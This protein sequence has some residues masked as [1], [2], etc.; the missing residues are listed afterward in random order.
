MS[1]TAIHIPE[2]PVAAWLSKSP[3]L[4]DQPLVVLRGTPPQ[5]SVASVNT[6][7]VESGISHGMSKV[8]AETAC[9]AHFRK[10]DEKEESE[11]FRLVE[12]TT[13][14]FSPR[15]QA[16][17]APANDYAGADRLTASLLIDCSGTGLLFG[18]ARSYAERLQ[19]ELEVVGFPCAVATAPNAEAALI[20][21]RSNCGIICVEQEQL[22]DKL[23]RLPAS[24]LPCDAKTHAVLQRW[25]IKTLGQLASLPTTGLISRLG[26]NGHRL[27]QLARGEAPRLLAPIEEAFS[28]TESLQLDFPI[29]GLQRLSV[30]LAHLLDAI[31]RK[32][33]EH[34]YAVRTL[35]AT[36]V[37]DRAQTH[38]VH[39][40]P[41]NPS[42]NRDALLKLLDLE[43][44]AHPPQSE[45]VAIRL[46]ADPAQPQRAQRGLFQSQFPES[47]KL[48]LLVARLRSI[49]GER[50]VGSPELANSHR[51]D[52]FVL[53]PFRPEPAPADR[54]QARPMRS[55]LRTFRPAQSVRVLLAN[56]RPGTVFWSGAKLNVADA[57][58]PWRKSGSWWDRSSF[59]YDYWDVL[60]AEPAYM[61]RLQQEHLSHTWKLVGLYD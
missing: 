16:I 54:E 19:R 3:A 44:Q 37:L 28:L 49:A 17:S 11:A 43:L 9:R 34:A 14:K 4:R 59:D 40:A 5:E 50:N 8:Q 26:Q 35:T 55:A 51:E 46:E 52:A 27:Q 7:A 33:I 29:D 42:Q 61:L 13:G 45:V 12:E 22:R 20:L 60:T 25:G 41:A 30:A 2:F 39:I 31:L 21:S 48:D 57:A 24:L 6:V 47:D 10:R 1:F 32:A 53:A 56:E 18:T 23:T 15:V 36:F 58:G 38:V